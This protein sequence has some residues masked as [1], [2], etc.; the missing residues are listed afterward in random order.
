MRKRSLTWLLRWWAFTS[1]LLWCTQIKAAAVSQRCFFTP[2]HAWGGLM[3]STLGLQIKKW[4]VPS[5]TSL[6]TTTTNLPRKMQ[7]QQLKTRE[8]LLLCK[9]KQ[10]KSPKLSTARGRNRIGLLILDRETK[11]RNESEIC[12]IIIYTYIIH[13]LQRGNFWLLRNFH[14]RVLTAHPSP[15][16]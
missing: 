6:Q 3:S 11:K 14:F 4:T 13:A 7:H 2:A 16:S 8:T 1:S 5:G 15:C 10:Q 12:K 9:R